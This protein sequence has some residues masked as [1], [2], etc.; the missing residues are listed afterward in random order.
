M[1][2]EFINLLPITIPFTFIP[3][4]KFPSN[5]CR[6]LFKPDICIFQPDSLFKTEFHYPVNHIERK[7]AKRLFTFLPW[8]GGLFGMEGDLRR[9]DA[10]KVREMLLFLWDLW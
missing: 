3:K 7:D 6:S 1:V 4:P 9:F 8:D 10:G 5:P 2:I